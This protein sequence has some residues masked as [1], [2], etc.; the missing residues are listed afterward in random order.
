MTFIK[1]PNYITIEELD[2]LIKVESNGRFM[3][4]DV[5]FITERFMRLIND[6]LSDL[7]VRI[8]KLEMSKQ[9]LEDYEAEQNERN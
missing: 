2:E 1:N 8:S 9:Q 5:R 3:K 7:H 6:R 4:E